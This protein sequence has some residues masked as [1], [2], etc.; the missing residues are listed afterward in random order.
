MI[1]SQI[2]HISVDSVRFFQ[3]LP[4]FFRNNGPVFWQDSY[5]FSNWCEGLKTISLCSR[6]SPPE[7]SSGNFT[8]LLTR[9]LGT[10]RIWS[11]LNLDLRCIN[12][13]WAW[14]SK[15]LGCIE[16]SGFKPIR[17]FQ[18]LGW[19]RDILS[20][21]TLWLLM[22]KTQENSVFL[23]WICGCANCFGSQSTAFPITCS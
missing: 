10:Y 16:D 9:P 17:N 14:R 1:F 4:H 8:L 5:L 21:W 11:L 18:T 15:D 7:C 20:S 22:L 6:M 13:L 3:L 2:W 23:S 19:T 12:F